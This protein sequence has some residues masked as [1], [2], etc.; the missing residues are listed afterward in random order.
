MVRDDQLQH[1]RPRAYLREQQ[2]SFGLVSECNNELSVKEIICMCAYV[3]E[4]CVSLISKNE[5]HHVGKIVETLVDYILDK[6]MIH[7][8]C[9]FSILAQ[10][11]IRLYQTSS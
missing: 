2:K 5:K 3:T 8:L 6:N 4:L 11:Y 9:I 1:D 10:K 7:V